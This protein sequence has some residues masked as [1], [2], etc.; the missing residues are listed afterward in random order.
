MIVDIKESLPET[1]KDPLEKMKQHVG[2]KV[3]SF[4]I[5]TISIKQAKQALRNLKPKMSSGIQ[6]I[7][8]KIIRNANNILAAPFQ[9]IFNQSIQTHTFPKMFK[10]LT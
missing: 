4:D 5:Q 10:E 9:R 6:G 3:M 8:K 1:G 7:P 2:N